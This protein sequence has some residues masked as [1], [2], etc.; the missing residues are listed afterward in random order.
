MVAVSKCLRNCSGG[1]SRG[2]ICLWVDWAMS[3]RCGAA[4][5]TMDQDPSEA[6]GISAEHRYGGYRR[7]VG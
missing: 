1:C 3:G 2:K 5:K 7:Y 6:R 4:S